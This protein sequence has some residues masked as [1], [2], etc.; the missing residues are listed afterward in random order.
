MFFSDQVLN[1]ACK[2]CSLRSTLAYT[3]IRLGYFWG[4]QYVLNNNGVS[5]VS[6]ASKKAIELFDSIKDKVDYREERYEDFLPWQSWGKSHHPIPQLRTL[7]LNQLRDDSITLEESIESFHHQQSLKRKLS[8]I[9]K[10]IVHA[11]P[12]R[13]EK[14]IRWAFYKLH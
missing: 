7:L 2:D 3:D 13:F 4:K 5:A 8:R 11:L 10:N 1:E 6:L 12:V 14:I 9:G